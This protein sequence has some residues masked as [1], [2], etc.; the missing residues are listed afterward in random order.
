MTAAVSST[1]NFP[2]P[3]APS[4]PSREPNA[5]EATIIKRLMT[6]K[7]PALFIARELKIS[8]QKVVNLGT[9][10]LGRIAF[11]KRESMA[12][13]CMFQMLNHDWSVGYTIG[14]LATKYNISRSTVFR[15]LHAQPSS[16]IITTNAPSGSSDDDPVQIIS[17]KGTLLEDASSAPVH[18]QNPPAKK[19][20]K[21]LVVTNSSDDDATN[22]P[23]ESI[24]VDLG[25]VKLRFAPTEA[26][27][28]AA[29]CFVKQIKEFL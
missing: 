5:L 7:L 6:T 15:L 2:A 21:P 27:A 19:V 22:Y 13:A 8:K 25:K 23:G 26:A 10:N 14:L 11:N 18:N 12:E 17:I 3:E 16:S 24:E 28:C 1:R 29:G 9:E 20:P 4:S